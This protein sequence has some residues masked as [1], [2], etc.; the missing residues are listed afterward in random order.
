MHFSSSLCLRHQIRGCELRSCR[1]S[2]QVP[3]ANNMPRVWDIVGIRRAWDKWQCSP[4]PGRQ[5]LI[6]MLVAMQESRPSDSQ[7][8]FFKKDFIYLFMGVRDR[9]RDLAEGE[10]GSLWGARYSTQSQHPGITTWAKSRCSTTEPP[11]CPLKREVSKNPW[12]HFKNCHIV[13]L[14]FYLF[15]HERHREREAEA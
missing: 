13:F 5:D 8:W 4:I 6:Q 9:G 12:D 11:R 14:R 2:G 1:V 10:A 15:I 3:R 7:S